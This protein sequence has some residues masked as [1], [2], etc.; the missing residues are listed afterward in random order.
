MLYYK[1]M[2]RDR[3]SP[4]LISRLVGLGCVVIFLLIFIPSFFVIIEAGEVGVYS[5]FGK[6]NDEPF[7]PGFNF[8]IHSLVFLECIESSGTRD[9]EI[10]VSISDS[11]F[12]S[13]FKSQN[14]QPSN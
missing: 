6:V 7:Y 12:L 3:I 14:H 9:F 8:K 4:K 2:F 1:N 13:I 5:L 10:I 11:I